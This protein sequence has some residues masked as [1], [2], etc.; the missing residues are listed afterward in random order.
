MNSDERLD[1]SIAKL[2]RSVQRDVP[3]TLDRRIREASDRFTSRAERS[4]R[5]RP[6]L[7]ALIPGAAAALLAAF[8]LFPRPA[9]AP[10]PISEIRTEFEIAGKNIKVVFFQKPD[11]HLFEEERNEKD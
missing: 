3:P 2:V 10:N 11:F 6:W 5:R 1:E 7:L 8:L 9:T 4:D